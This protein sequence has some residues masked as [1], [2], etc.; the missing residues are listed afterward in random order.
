MHSGHIVIDLASEQLLRPVGRVYNY[1]CGKIFL[2][3]TTAVQLLC[4]YERRLMF[5]LG[6]PVGLLLVSGVLTA[7][8]WPDQA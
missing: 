2:T 4:W 3:V 5:R 1:L 8:I 6:Q 7:L